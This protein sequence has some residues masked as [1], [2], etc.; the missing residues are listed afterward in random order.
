VDD[1]HFFYDETRVR[2]QAVAELERLAAC[3]TSEPF[4]EVDL[5]LIGRTD[6]RGGDAYN[7]RLGKERANRV[8]K[9]LVDYG[10]SAGRTELQS[11][12]ESEAR[13]DTPAASYGY[14]RRV[15]IVQLQ[16]KTP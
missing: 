5:K 11:E 6:P 9:M 10:V 16:A 7:E 1:P 3:L 14:D 15:D 8:K 13:G 2:P 12:G 4:G